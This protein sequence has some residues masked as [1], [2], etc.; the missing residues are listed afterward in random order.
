MSEL[1]IVKRLK[2]IQRKINELSKKQVV[3]GAIGGGAREDGLTN[4]ELLAIHEFGSAKKG[5]PERPVMRTSFKKGEAGAKTLLSQG[6]SECLKGNI[7]TDQA[8]E[9]AGL[10][11]RNTVVETFVENDFTPNDPKTIKRKK[12]SKPLIDTG[13]LRASIS[14]EVR[15]RE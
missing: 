1:N 7:S 2:E 5:I 12:S 9:R 3:V 13:A 15:N 11:L 14:Y 6:V 10:F 8:Y 4:A